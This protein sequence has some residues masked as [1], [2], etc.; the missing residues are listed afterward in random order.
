MLQHQLNRQCLIILGNLSTFKNNN[1][2]S[3]LIE[4]FSQNIDFK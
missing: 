2:F 3:H 1:T 4:Y